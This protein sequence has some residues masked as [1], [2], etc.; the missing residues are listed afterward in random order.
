[1]RAGEGEKDPRNIGLVFELYLKVLSI[2]PA[3]QLLAYRASMF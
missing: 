2:Y 1:M 3:E